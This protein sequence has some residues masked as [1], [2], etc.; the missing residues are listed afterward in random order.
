MMD[1]VTIRV[2][3]RDKERFAK[4]TGNKKL[5]EAFRFALSLAEREIEAF[6]GNLEALVKAHKSVRSVGGN[7][8]KN[9]DRTLAEGLYV[10]E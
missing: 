9:I 6:H 7:V 4:K 5:S 1:S 8:S 10:E 2:P 3:R